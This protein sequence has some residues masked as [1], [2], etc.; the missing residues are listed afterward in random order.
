LQPLHPNRLG[1][2][3]AGAWLAEHAQAGDV[4]EDDHC[5]AH[6]YA[7]KVFEEGHNPPPAP[8]HQPVCYIVV[9]RSRDVDVGRAR[10][11]SEANIRQAQGQLV[12]YWPQASVDDARVVV[13]ALPR[14]ASGPFLHSH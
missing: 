3:L 12:Y 4:V 6:Y 2:L 10:S 13:Y 7:G 9:T 14:S 5:W 1:H 8:G 11:V